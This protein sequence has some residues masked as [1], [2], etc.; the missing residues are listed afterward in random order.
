VRVLGY[1][2]SLPVPECQSINPQ[3][4]ATASSPKLRG[5]LYVCLSDY[6][7]RRD[8]PTTRN[9]EHLSARTARQAVWGVVLSTVDGDV[10]QSLG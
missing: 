1:C 8:V 3:K 7:G 2:L 5:A 9:H 6:P 4:G 10:N